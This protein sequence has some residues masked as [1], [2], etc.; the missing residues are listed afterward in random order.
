MTD[1]R[2]T[3]DGWV[4]PGTHVTAMGSDVPDKHEVDPALLSR[5]KVVADSLA[6]C[7]TQGEIHQAIEAGAITADDIYAELGEIAAGLKPGR[8]DD[9]EITLADLT[10]VGVLDAAVASLVVARAKESG[11]GEVIET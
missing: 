10:G 5:A 2:T 4:E 3:I 1:V 11:I 9:E 7:L 6:Q 8:T